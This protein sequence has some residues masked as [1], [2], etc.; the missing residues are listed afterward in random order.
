MVLEFFFVSFFIY[1][2]Y[3]MPYY[4]VMQV[5]Q[6]VKMK[7]IRGKFLDTL[8]L[9]VKGGTGGTGL[10]RYGGIGGK[11]G[12]VYVE[13]VE[14]MVALALSC[15]YTLGN[16]IHFVKYPLVLLAV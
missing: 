13:T 14:G 9:H 4:A 1:H 2:E 10:P 15:I 8:R 6:K 16:I 11:G 3:I 5:T 12:D 7:R